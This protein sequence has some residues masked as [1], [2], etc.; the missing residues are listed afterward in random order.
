MPDVSSPDYNELLGKWADN[1][2]AASI[3]K[4]ST[5]Y[6]ILLRNKGYKRK[7]DNETTEDF[8]MRMM[9]ISTYDFNNQSQYAKLVHGF[10]QH[11]H[12]YGVTRVNGCLD[13]NKHCKKGYTNKPLAENTT[14]DN[15]GFPLYIRP[16]K[17]NILLYHTIEICF[18]IGGGT[19][20]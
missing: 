8:A 9:T 3:P 5:L 15:K 14:F 19:L 12:S 16:P 11:E 17:R 13:K 1:E 4:N 20:A 6:E 7:K 10:I 18:L 2:V